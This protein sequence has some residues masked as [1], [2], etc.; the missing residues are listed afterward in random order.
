MNIN[1]LLKKNYTVLFAF[2]GSF[3]VVMF[4][5]NYLQNHGENFDTDIDLNGGTYFQLVYIG[6]SG[7]SFCNESLHSEVALLKTKLKNIV[8]ERGFKFLSTGIST[9]LDSKEGVKFL[10][11]ISE[12][13]ELISGG[14][15]YNL[16]VYYY[17]WDTFKDEGSVPQIIILKNDFV[18]TGSL[19][20][21]QD[22]ER[23]DNLLFRLTTIQEVQD[24]TG[25]VECAM[26][27][28]F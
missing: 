21:I 26:E 16:G 3:F 14:S 18:V 9:S 12:F 13:D 23:N 24:F 25:N 4:L 6:S 11:N 10:N 15:W 17:I 5:M 1:K 7:C 8:N 27:Q 20:G 28:F 19:N 22:I 2:L